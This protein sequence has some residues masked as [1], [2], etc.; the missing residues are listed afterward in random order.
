MRVHLMYPNLITM[1]YGA[2]AALELSSPQPLAP[3]ITGM[4]YHVCV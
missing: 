2:E 1:C 4:S 3:K